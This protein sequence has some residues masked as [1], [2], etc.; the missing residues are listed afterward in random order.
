[1]SRSTEKSYFCQFLPTIGMEVGRGAQF[2]ISVLLAGNP[3]FSL[4]FWT[5]IP[6]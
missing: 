2:K 1:M 6:N 4:T 5:A 3:D